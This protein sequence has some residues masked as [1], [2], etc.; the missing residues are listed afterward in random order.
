MTRLE[1]LTTPSHSTLSF[2]L[3][4]NGDD[5]GVTVSYKGS[6]SS[7][8]VENDKPEEWKCDCGLY[9]LLLHYFLMFYGSKDYCNYR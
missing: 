2:Y 4:N 7:F 8:L 1:P 6:R 9:Q 5:G 3:L